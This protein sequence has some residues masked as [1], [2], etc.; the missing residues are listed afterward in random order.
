MIYIYIYSTYN[1]QIIKHIYI[2]DINHIL[3]D[4][5]IYIKW[6]WLWYT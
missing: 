3:L 5:Y 6:I 4:T 2:L 1:M